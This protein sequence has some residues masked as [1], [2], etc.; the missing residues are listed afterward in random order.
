M[1]FWDK[2]IWGKY[3]FGKIGIWGNGTLG[4]YYIKNKKYLFT[5]VF[6]GPIN[7]M[8]KTNTS[9]EA[10]SSQIVCAGLVLGAKDLDENFLTLKL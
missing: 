8:N 3:K 10:G 2:G 7:C 9:I 5:C 6:G 1:G 4:K